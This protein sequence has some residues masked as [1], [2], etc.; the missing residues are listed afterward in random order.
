ML[1][2]HK[3]SVLRIKVTVSFFWLSVIIAVAFVIVKLFACLYKC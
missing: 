2:Q 3:P 1:A